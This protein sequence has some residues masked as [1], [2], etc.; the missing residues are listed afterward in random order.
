MVK[1]LLFDLDGTLLDS[2]DDLTVAINNTFASRSLPQIER[3]D[4]ARFIGKGARVLVQRSLEKVCGQKPGDETVDNVLPDYLNEMKLAEGTRTKQLP[5]VPE[6]LKRLRNAGFK[7]A[8][9]TNKPAAI[10]RRLLSQFNLLMYFETIIGAGDV[11]AIKPNPLML[12]EAAHRMGIPIREC[13]MIGDS[14]NDSLA[15]KN[16]HIHA[17]LV[18]TGYN[19]GVAIDQWVLEYA[20]DDLV[21]DTMTELAQFLI[22]NERRI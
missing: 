20:T 5:G 3:S 12:T 8:V 16:A 6:A 15:A 4:V 11:A 21:F 17:L 1:A 7:M 18:K 14:M 22:K 10:A 13:V 2:V 19:E 9:V